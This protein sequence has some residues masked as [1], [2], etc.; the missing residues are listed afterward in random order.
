MGAKIWPSPDQM[1]TSRVEGSPHSS[2]TG[3]GDSGAFF[4]SAGKPARFYR[5]IGLLGCKFTVTA[6]IAAPSWQM[7]N[8][9]LRTQLWPVSWP[10]AKP[11]GKAGDRIGSRPHLCTGAIRRRC[12][13]ADAFLLS[14]SLPFGSRHLRSKTCKTG[15]SSK[16]TDIAFRNSK[17]R[18]VYIHKLPH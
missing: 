14:Y 8:P 1:R 3:L 15:A 2:I 18:L 9:Q 11:S 17:R 5:A 10:C 16:G 4:V 6:A 7:Q 13:F 12:L